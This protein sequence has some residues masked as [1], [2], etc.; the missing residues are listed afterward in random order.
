MCQLGLA[1]CVVFSDGSVMAQWGGL[2]RVV[3]RLVKAEGWFEVWLFS[4]GS[5]WLR[6][7]WP[8]DIRFSIG[9]LLVQLSQHRFALVQ[10]G[11]SCGSAW[12]SC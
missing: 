6:C 10:L 7:W 9:L 3:S 12:F 4:I 8:G 2:I 1:N 5:S 11:L